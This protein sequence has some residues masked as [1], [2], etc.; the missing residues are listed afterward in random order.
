[1][2]EGNRSKESG[3]SQLR[4]EPT[5]EPQGAK[6]GRSARVADGFIR[7]SKTRD[8]CSYAIISRLLSGA[9]GCRESPCRTRCQ[10]PVATA[11]NGIRCSRDTDGNA[12]W[13]PSFASPICCNAV[14]LIC[15]K[16]HPNGQGRHCR[17]TLILVCP[18]V[19]CPRHAVNNELFIARANGVFSTR[20]ACNSSILAALGRPRG[21]A[22]RS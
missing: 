2:P 13:L 8:V 22:C 18:R 1:M 14:S 5:T 9:M 17:V 4:I 21:V 12:N 3:L 16:S 20:C 15:C 6:R 11:S 7:L 10:A 19:D